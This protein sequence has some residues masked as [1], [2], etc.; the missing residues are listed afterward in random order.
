[1]RH[2]SADSGAGRRSAP[3]GVPAAE[4]A[5]V[6][7][8]CLVAFFLLSRYLLV[9]PDT[10]VTLRNNVLFETDSGVRLRYLTQPGM[11]P[12]SLTEFMQHPAFFLVWRPVG[13]ALT[14][15]F[16][17]FTSGSQAAVLAVQALI[18]SAAAVGQAMLYATVRRFGASRASALLPVLLLTLATSATLVVVPEHWAMAQGLMLS[19]CFVAAWPGRPD[20]RRIIVLAALLALIAATT[21]TNIV[22]G[23]ALA[24]P[25]AAAAGMRRPDRRVLTGLGFAAVVSVI[26]AGFVVRSLPNIAGFLNLRLAEAP[27]RALEYGAFGLIAPIVGPVPYA[28]IE[29]QHLALSYEPVS[30]GMYSTLQWIGVV[31]WCILLVLGASRALRDRQTRPLAAALVA[32][33]GFNLV[34]HNLWGD[35]FFL[36]SAHWAWALVLLVAIGLRHLR[37]RVLLPVTCL[38]VIGQIAAMTTIGQMLRQGTDAAEGSSAQAV[39]MQCDPHRITALPGAAPAPEAERPAMAAT[40]RCFEAMDPLL[41]LPTHPL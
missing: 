36:Y 20:R 9:S 17:L 24:I 15:L 10:E 4:L 18:C 29:R 34:F 37:L 23:A 28:S 12:A 38:I 5:A 31:A 8:A 14:K 3:A 22:L 30:F 11:R 33:V 26:A 39:T 40:P 35:E 27:L 19:A 21:V 13:L 1:M 2:E 16:G 6:F 32:W 41:S 25:V 7:A